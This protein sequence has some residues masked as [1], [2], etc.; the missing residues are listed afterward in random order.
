MVEGR[1]ASGVLIDFLQ[2]MVSDSNKPIVMIVDG[3]SFHKSK[4]TRQF[5]RNQGDWLRLFFLPPYAPELNPDEQVWNQLKSRIGK[6]PVT[7]KADL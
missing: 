7:G 4:Q 2:K 6:T 1:V 5:V 3:A